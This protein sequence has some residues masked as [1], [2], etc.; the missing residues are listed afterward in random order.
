M[1]R[2]FKGYS[3]N[4]RW[5]I[6]KK[7]IN[8]SLTKEKGKKKLTKEDKFCSFFKNT[9]IPRKFSYKFPYV[10][11]NTKREYFSRHVS[12]IV[13]TN[14]NRYVIKIIL[15]AFLMLWWALYHLYL[16]KF[17]IIVNDRCIF[18][19]STFEFLNKNYFSEIYFASEHLQ[20]L[21]IAN[22]FDTN[23]FNTYI[24]YF[25]L[26]LFPTV[27]IFDVLLNFEKYK[28]EEDVVLLGEDKAVKWS[29]DFFSVDLLDLQDNFLF[30]FVIYE[31]YLE[32]NDYLFNYFNHTF[33]SKSL[34][35]HDNC[36]KIKSKD[37]KPFNF[38]TSTYYSFC[39]EYLDLG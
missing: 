3:Y 33:F 14:E 16:I 24:N 35:Y 5:S 38:L 32:F 13:L 34:I 25:N 30:N 22:Y 12:A 15:H 4:K 23:Y 37:V 7:L 28:Y 2:G 11:N 31:F 10:I 21:N 26:Y 36:L 19:Y 20:D 18:G 27:K 1:L 39:L 17:T 29:M 6:T 9:L 8:T